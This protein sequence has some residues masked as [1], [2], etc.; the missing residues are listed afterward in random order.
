MYNNRSSIYACVFVGLA[1]GNQALIQVA[2]H[3]GFSFNTYCIG[4]VLLLIFAALY[5][6]VIRKATVYWGIVLKLT[7]V[8]ICIYAAYQYV[9]P[10]E[11]FGNYPLA[12]FII[13][14]AAL[15]IMA[16]DIIYWKNPFSSKIDSGVMVFAVIF[17]FSPLALSVIEKAIATHSLTLD[18]SKIELSHGNGN[19]LILILDELSPEYS[20]V[21]VEELLKAGL[22]VQTKNIVAAG[23]NT[24]NAI[25]SILTNERHDDV[26]PCSTTALCGGQFYDFS[27]IQAININ[28]D[29]VGFYHPYCSIIGLRSC[30]QGKTNINAEDVSYFGWVVDRVCRRYS[31]WFCSEIAVTPILIEI[32]ER[33]LGAMDRAPFW[34]KGGLLF[35]HLLLP[36]LPA[37]VEKPTVKES[38]EGNVNEAAKLLS[39][40][41]VKL[42]SSF[43]DDFVLIVTSD[44]P[45]RH[46]A[47]NGCKEVARGEFK[48]D[49]LPK[50]NGYVP[51]IV[52]TSVKA[53]MSLPDSAV[54][55]LDIKNAPAFQ[56]KRTPTL[57]K[58]MVY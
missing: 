51:L 18:V 16:I 34:D 5:A 3:G 36:H 25:P 8:I 14:M 19:V 47:A 42:K 32:R 44:H 53:V 48:C 27:N 11:G 1:V 49:G 55:L 40:L 52:G 54:G 56:N 28:T 4:L 58:I 24:I 2:Y 30:F 15:I 43:G 20:P 31:L 21:L 9:L 13:I 46:H 37:V 33:L 35:V 57:L 50:N 22:F 23:A 38:Y 41:S 7:T 45:F 39:R 29:I 17:S 6:F 26:A 12:F 10:L